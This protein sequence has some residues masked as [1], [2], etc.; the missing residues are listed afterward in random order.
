[1]LDIRFI[2]ENA[3][4]VA[5]KAE[6]KGYKVDVAK[7]LE[8]DK[9]KR[10]LIEELESIYR[11]IRQLAQTGLRPD[12]SIAIQTV[13]GRQHREKAK[14]LEA[15]LKP[16]KDAINKLLQ[17]IPNVFPDDTPLGGEEANREEK[18][19][20]DT[21]DKDFEAVDHLTWGEQ[22]GLIDF[23]RGAKVAGNKFY[24]L[25]GPLV[26]LELAIAQLGLELAKKH[27]FTPMMVPHLV[28]TRTLEGAGF[29]AKGKEKQIYKVEDEDLNLIATA[30]IPLTG[31]HTDEIINEKDLPILYAG[32]SPAYR[33]EGGAYGKHNR[34]LFRTHQFNKLELYI[35]CTPDKSEE[36][37]QKMVALEEE[38]CQML[39][40]PYRIVRIAAGDLGA[41]AYKKF[42]IEYWTPVDKTYR[43][44][45]SCSNVTDYQAR[46]LNIRYKNASGEN[47]YVH[48]LNGTLAVM[49]RIP[50]ALI[51]NH[52]NKDGSVKIPETLQPYMHGQGSF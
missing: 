45:M 50:I 43:E 17:E 39:E 47:Q 12:G 8:L 44:L 32:L 38:F 42:D 33:V 30:E 28:N 25:K 18:K 19:W 14:E 10:P 46:R 5:K 16:T 2:R 31:Y 52:Q 24:F 23:E 35:F 1:M 51:E 6:Q 40:I 13:A 15:K 49:S 11:I 21:K 34:G 26:E 27:G 20:G 36:L 4:L 9:E 22:R 48:T 3:E 41:P 37:H 7:L 29:S